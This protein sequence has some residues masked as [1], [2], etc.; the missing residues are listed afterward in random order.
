M[1]SVGRSLSALW[2]RKHSPVADSLVAE[3]DNFHTKLKTWL[4][5]LVRYAL[6]EGLEAFVWL[7]VV[8]EGAP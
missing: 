4:S 1:E 8:A 6:V 5:E 7:R 3:K 2:Q